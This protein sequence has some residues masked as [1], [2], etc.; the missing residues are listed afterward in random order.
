MFLQHWGSLLQFPPFFT[1]SPSQLFNMHF[2]SASLALPLFFK[3]MCFTH[4]DQFWSLVGS[5]QCLKWVTV[6]RSCEQALK[7]NRFE[8][9]MW[10]LQLSCG[11]KVAIDSLPYH[12]HSHTFTQTSFFMFSQLYIHHIP[13]LLTMLF[14]NDF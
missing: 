6:R 11:M 2:A 7:N 4:V 1:S 12:F 5:D 8:Q 9:K 14:A 10:I 13:R 3:A